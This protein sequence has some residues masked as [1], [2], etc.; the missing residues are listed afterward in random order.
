MSWS[1]FYWAVGC[2]LKNWSSHKSVFASENNLNISLS[3]EFSN[4]LINCKLKWISESANWSLEEWSYVCMQLGVLPNSKPAV[5]VGFCNAKWG[6]NRVACPP[7]TWPNKYIF[8]RKN[9]VAFLNYHGFFIFYIY[10]D[11]CNQ[12]KSSSDWSSTHRETFYSWCG[13]GV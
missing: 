9:G 3:S 7:P 12:H 5:E 2:H 4:F 6:C 1:P 10:L 13:K 8:H 11:M